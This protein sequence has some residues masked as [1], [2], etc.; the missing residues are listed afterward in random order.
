MQGGLA[1][2]RVRPFGR[3]LTSYTVNDLGDAVGVVA[4]SVLVY[5]RTHAVA[6]TAAFFVCGKFLPA[7]LAPVLTA[8]V[9]QWALRRALPT[10][11]VLEAAVFAVLALIAAGHFLLVP[12][13]VL[14]L[15]D[16][17]LALT[18]RGLTRGAVGVVLKDAGLL[19]QGN[20]LMN[21]GFAI[22]SV[23]GAGLGGLLISRAGL[24]AALLVDAATF[25]A[26]AALLAATRGLPGVHLDPEPFRERL[27]AGLGFAR[28]SG[29]VRTL[30]GGQ[31]LALLCF[32]I[33]VPI[34]VIYAKSSLG[35]DSAGF[36]LLLASW[37]AGI[38]VG[39]LLYLAVRGHSSPALVLVSTAAVG[40]AYLGLANAN[41][42][43]IAC[44]VSIL[45]GVGNGI[46]WIAVMTALQEATPVDY[47]ARVT[48][49]M[50]SVAA[51]VPGVGYILGATIVALASPRAAYA[52][53]GLGVMALVIGAL[54]LRVDL[55]LK[56]GPSRPLPGRARPGRA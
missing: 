39:S 35:T 40:G 43:L 24:P 33:I 49:L 12:V 17:V 7:F 25:L 20:A 1:P 22:A 50:E 31:A 27:R 30:L 2:V 16:G 8:R 26:I 3:L 32:T 42:L 23:G 55:G 56:P 9:D 21:L 47:Q 44:L 45:G 34:E 4:L 41:T 14:A 54:V 53:A 51:A 36:G 5:D 6:A 38:F 15:V 52:I 37:G 11:Y 29:P 48:G 10:L 28:Q 46:Q 19:R 13:L 18:G